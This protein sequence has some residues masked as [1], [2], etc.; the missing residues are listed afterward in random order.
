MQIPG[1][2]TATLML[3]TNLQL[4]WCF[5]RLSTQGFAMLLL[6]QTRVLV[7]SV[8]SALVAKQNVL[9]T[10]CTMRTIRNPFVLDMVS[11][12]MPL[13]KEMPIVNV[14]PGFTGSLV[15]TVG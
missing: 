10:L 3:D 6:S 12:G 11:A 4:S 15:S 5:L 7:H 8:E 2:A 14:Q 13:T 9:A 1:V